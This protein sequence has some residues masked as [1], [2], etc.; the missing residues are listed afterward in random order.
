MQCGIYL[1]YRQMAN[2]RAVKSLH[3]RENFQ[4]C[5]Q[6][7]R[8]Q[9]VSFQLTHQ[10]KRVGKE[11]G[12]AEIARFQGKNHLAFLRSDGTQYRH[13]CGNFYAHKETRD[14]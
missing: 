14:A 1:K 3:F 6:A 2:D 10:I 11:T 13:A 8:L 5:G 4:A 12:T 7:R 9:S